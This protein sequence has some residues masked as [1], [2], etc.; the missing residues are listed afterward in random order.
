MKI[1]VI[2]I[3]VVGLYCMASLL[4]AKVLVVV[5]ASALVCQSQVA[6]GHAFHL[7]NAVPGVGPVNQLVRYL[8][9]I[10]EIY[11]HGNLVH[12]NFAHVLMEG[13]GV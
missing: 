1:V 9:M 13:Y 8:M 2:A 10:M 5:I 12:V 11:C 3:L 4:V 7:V 6:R